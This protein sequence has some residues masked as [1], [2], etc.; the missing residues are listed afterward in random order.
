MQGM[1]LLLGLGICLAVAALFRECWI[2]YECCKE[3]K[4]KT[5]RHPSVPSIVLTK[6][7]SNF[8]NDMNR[9]SVSSKLS[10]VC[11]RAVS[12]TFAFGGNSYRKIHNSLRR[13]SQ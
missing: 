5:S 13:F 8:D 9:V 11:S 4:M 12:A 6:C 3:I 1:F 2:G 7:D 10:L